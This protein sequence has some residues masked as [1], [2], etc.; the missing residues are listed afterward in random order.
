MNIFEAV[1]KDYLSSRPHTDALQ[2]RVNEQVRAYEEHE[3]LGRKRMLERSKTP[4]DEGFVTVVSSHSLP[5][6][7]KKKRKEQEDSRVLHGNF[8]K[9]Q[10]RQTRTDQLEELKRKFEDDKARLALLR[11]NKI[12]ND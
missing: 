9:F 11:K 3:Q 1:L 4:D 12:F 7:K 10:S 5:L 8:Y 6:M 2:R